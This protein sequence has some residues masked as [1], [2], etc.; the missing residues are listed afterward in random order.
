MQVTE[1]EQSMCQVGVENPLMRSLQTG[2]K[3][4]QRCCSRHLAGVRMYG[5]GFSLSIVSQCY[6]ADL[7]AEKTG[8]E[9][10]ERIWKRPNKAQC[11]LV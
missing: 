10:W 7:D 11:Y 5:T 3:N 2:R 1:A 4:F 6:R 9:R 8:E